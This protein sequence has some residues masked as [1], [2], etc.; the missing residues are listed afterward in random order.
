MSALFTQPRSESIRSARIASTRRSLGR[1]GA[2]RQGE[3]R[4]A[5]RV[6][7]VGVL[8]IGRAPRPRRQLHHRVERRLRV[9]VASRRCPPGPATAAPRSR[10]STA[11]RCSAVGR[12]SAL[13]GPLAQ[14]LAPDE[15]RQPRSAPRVASSPSR[16]APT[17]A[18][19]R[20]SIGAPPSSPARRA[21]PARRPRPARA[22]DARRRLRR[23][24]RLPLPQR[25]SPSDAQRRAKHA[26]LITA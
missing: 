5:P 2:A 10:G 8:G 12:R 16:R 9:V 17:R 4:A 18:A 25:A 13:V 6:Q 14:P 21:C 19:S 20:A 3:Q 24:R 11:S 7:L 1:S 26:P 15:I 23:A 22:G